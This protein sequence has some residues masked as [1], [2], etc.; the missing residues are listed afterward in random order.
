NCGCGNLGLAGVPEGAGDNLLVD[1]T[2]FEYRRPQRWELVVF[3]YPP[4][5][6]RSYI[7]RVVGLPGEEVQI[8]DGDVYIDRSLLSKTLEALKKGRNPVF[9]RNRVPGWRG[10]RSGWA[11]TPTGGEAVAAGPKLRIDGP[12]L[13]GQYQRLVY[14]NVALDERREWPMTDAYAYN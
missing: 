8:R 3:R 13:S 1:K 5:P 10:C 11:A 4:D 9:D 14:C 2:A 6:S 12:R 7:K